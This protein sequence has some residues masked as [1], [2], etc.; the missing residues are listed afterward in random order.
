MLPRL[1]LAAFLLA[2]G[3]IHLGY[4]SPRP[5]DTAGPAW[6][7]ELGRSWLLGPLGLEPGLIRA[8]GM[9]LTIVTVAAFVGAAIGALGLF[10]GAWMAAVVVGTAASITL[11]VVF[12]HPW[13]LLGVAIDAALLWV[14]MA[15]GW[16]PAQLPA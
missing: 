15:Q 14:A 1:A 12:F 13:L 6:P 7:F 16:S 9:A 4:V 10:P 5:P 3:A 8:I 11:L 2:H